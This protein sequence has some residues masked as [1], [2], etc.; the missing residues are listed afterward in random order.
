[1]K[2]RGFL[3]IHNISQMALG[4]AI[5]RQS[6]KF[7]SEIKTFD[8]LVKAN[9][10]LIKHLELELSPILNIWSPQSI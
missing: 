9:E 1:M 4:Q 5:K 10:A 8:R 3:P 2:N 7:P 6:A